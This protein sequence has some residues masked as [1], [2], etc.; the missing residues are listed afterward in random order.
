MSTLLEKI[1]EQVAP[2]IPGVNW[3]VLE[4][5]FGLPREQLVYQSDVNKEPEDTGIF[6]YGRYISDALARAQVQ[7]QKVQL[8]Y[9][10]KDNP[11]TA[12]DELALTMEAWN[13]VQQEA[14]SIGDVV[15]KALKLG[16]ASVGL[17][18]R[19]IVHRE[20]YRA[21]ITATYV[22]CLYSAVVHAKKIMQFENISGAEIVRSADDTAKTLNAL[23]LLGELGAL[24][25]LKPPEG[26]SGAPVVITVAIASAFIIGVVC[27]TVVTTRR[28]SDY[29]KQI[30]IICELAAESG[31]QEAIERCTGLVEMHVTSREGGPIAATARNVGNAAVSIAGSILLL[32]LTP[33]LVRWIS[34]ADNRRRSFS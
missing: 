28:L 12:E 32:F 34:H 1:A 21:A 25:V 16:E 33:T 6:A 11:D 9:Q 24:D 15:L 29:N 19:F 13:E 23:A 8:S 22:I 10:V 26:V 18:N 14:L 4:A 17:N 31:N 20:A 30:E 7:L 27:Y 2:R 5:E 3:Q